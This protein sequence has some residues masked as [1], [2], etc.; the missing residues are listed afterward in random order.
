MVS[1]YLLSMVKLHSPGN[2]SGD[3]QHASVEAFPYITKEDGNKNRNKARP[4]Q[5]Q[6]SGSLEI[7]N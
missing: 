3:S 1:H 5:F 2:I 7:P 6:I 4:A